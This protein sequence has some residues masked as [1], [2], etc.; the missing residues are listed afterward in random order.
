[1]AKIGLAE[2]L[3]DGTVATSYTPG[4]SADWPGT[5]PT[6]QGGALDRLALLFARRVVTKRLVFADS[7]YDIATHPDYVAG[8]AQRFQVYL[9]TAGGA[10]FVK[11][12][13]VA[14]NAGTSVLVVE[15]AGIAGGELQDSGGSLIANI[16]AGSN[17]PEAT[18]DGTTWQVD[19]NTF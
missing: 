10:I 2:E 7:P 4:V 11:A 3:R 19:R 1:M 13:P 12:P 6:T 14:T 18:S 5:D 16:I 8:A 9:N 17:T 15:Y